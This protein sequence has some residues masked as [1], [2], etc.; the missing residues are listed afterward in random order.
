MKLPHLTV[1]LST[2]ALLLSGCAL[3]EQPI[4]ANSTPEASPSQSPSA[5]DRYVS[6]RRLA[7]EA[8]VMVQHPPHPVNTWQDARIK[9]RQAIRLL[10]DIPQNESVAAQAREKLAT[11]R[12][13]YAAISRRLETEQ[14]AVEQWEKAHTSAWQAAVTVQ[15]PPHSLRVWQRASLKWQEAIALLETIPDTTSVYPQS[16]EKLAIYRSNYHAINQR[17]ATETQALKTL[18]QFSELAVQLNN[19]P[20]RA[21][22]DPST[23]QIGISYPEYV[24][25][26]QKLES[27]LAQFAGQPDGKKH[28]IYADLEQAIADFKTVTKLWQAYLNYKQDNSQWLYDD[29]FNQLVPLPFQDIATLVQKYRIKTYSDGTKVSLRFAAWTIWYQAGQHIR[30]AQQEILSM[31]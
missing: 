29:V 26:V 11:Y 28:P 16:Q 27:S 20:N 23:N 17:I 2:G 15:D 1:M 6:A 21:S 24:S 31:S 5:L 19:I 10:E 7:W 13:N 22:A 18:K 25:L 30:K 9:W 3:V 14:A 12:T 4:A 8:A